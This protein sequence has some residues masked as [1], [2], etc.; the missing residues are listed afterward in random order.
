MTTEVT[1]S[2]GD[3]RR[4]TGALILS[5]ARRRAA[6]RCAPRQA[7]SAQA[8]FAD[9][10]LFR[11]LYEW[12]C[13]AAQPGR[14]FHVGRESK[15]VPQMRILS[16]VSVLLLIANQAPLPRAFPIAIAIDGRLTSND[17]ERLIEH[18]FDVPAGTRRIE[19]ALTFTGSERRTVI[20]LG[21]RDSED[22]RGW[23]GGRASRIHVSRLSAS[24]GYLP[25]PIPE[26]RWAVLLGVPN[27]RSDSADTYR[28]TVTLD[29]SDLAPFSTTVASGPGWFAGDLHAHS[30]HSDGRAR[31]RTGDLVPASVHQV[32]DAA[33]AAGLDFVALTDHN[34]ASHWVDV[35]RLQP[36]YNRVLLLHAR[37]ITTYRGHANTAGERTFSEF[38]LSLPSASPA[39]VL[40][41]IAGAGAFVSINHPTAPDD[42]RCMG[43]GWNVLDETVQSSVHGVEVVNGDSRAGPL[44]GWPF[45]ASLLNRGW[46]LTAVGGSDEH[47]PDESGDRTIGTPTTVVWARELSEPALVEGLKSGRVYIRTRGPRGPSLEFDVLAGDRTYQMGETVPAGSNIPLRLRAI[48]QD[49]AGHSL[50]WIVNGA[51]AGRVPVDAS[52]VTIEREAIANPGDW[53][54]VVLHEGDDPTLISNAIYVRSSTRR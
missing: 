1:V 48:V 39:D 6:S 51:T 10:T 25:G 37:E 18:P 43:C 36:L 46:R 9:S 45:W 50:E 13:R 26:G 30:G 34:T 54:S 21:L 23:S 35:D 52:P 29:S 40:A 16:L 33:T 42:E 28:V 14:P 3:F 19:V 2:A 20:D 24:P 4:V 5:Y 12:V 44:F 31:S 49:A 27:I 53:L 47:T 38:R 32:I 22:L 11:S 8:F 15:Y 17:Y 41:P 7:A